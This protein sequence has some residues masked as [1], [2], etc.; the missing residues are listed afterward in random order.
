MA[1]VQGMSFT[2]SEFSL[3]EDKGGNA[4]LWQDPAD[5]VGSADFF[6]EFVMLDGPDSAST[7]TVGGAEG[8][9][10]GRGGDYASLGL[11]KALTPPVS[12]GSSTSMLPP[13]RPVGVKQHHYTY[14]DPA[15]AIHPSIH[16][17]S[18]LQ[19]CHDVPSA[20]SISDSELLKLEGL[21]MRSPRVQ[22]PTVSASV[23]PSPRSRSASPRKP[24]RLE[25][26]YTKVRNKA[27]TLQ[28]KPKQQPSQAHNAPMPNISTAQMD[29]VKLASRPKPYN[30]NTAKPH[31]PLSPPLTGSV[32][33]SSQSSTVADSSSTSLSFVTGLMEDPFPEADGQRVGQLHCGAIPNTPLHT[34]LLNGFSSRSVGGPNGVAAWQLASSSAST[35]FLTPTTTNDAFWWDPTC[36]PMEMDMKMDTALQLTFAHQQQQQPRAFEYPPPP[37]SSTD[38]L[39][40]PSGLMIHMPQP[41]G[42]AAAVLHSPASAHHVVSATLA[43]PHYHY[44]PPPSLHLPNGSST[45]HGR[46]AETSPRRPK[47]PRAPSSGAR[48]HQYA[49]HPLCPGGPPFHPQSSPR[50]R[51]ASNNGPP[52]SPSPIPRLHRRSA[53]MQLLRNPPSDS[54][55][56][57][58]KRKSWTGRRP[59]DSTSP[60]KPSHA[61]RASSGTLPPTTTKPRGPSSSSNPRTAPEDDDNDYHLETPADTGGDGFVNYTPSD[62]N[63]LMAGVAPSGSSKTKARRER[64]ALEQQRKLG[65]A[66]RKAVAAAGGDVSKLALEGEGDVL[67]MLGGAEGLLEGR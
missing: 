12:L 56:A 63:I 30:L 45:R 49:V 58:R 36:D 44:P 26:F 32:L 39:F 8:G 42:P 28:G 62:H 60:R 37:T 46:P 34:P 50:K 2:A 52:P 14:G 53:S 5:E 25:T 64:E 59:S 20:G 13:G 51:T 21:T 9:G 17:L 57:I 65:E 22:V 23:P 10:G 24:G 16:D 33:D 55:S 1:S 31:L 11:L 43:Q 3:V 67:G 18:G 35:P 48:H 54:P 38:D 61:R 29:T 27:A 66:V 41:R 40:T 15:M 4:L 19:V 47:K 7:S 6:D